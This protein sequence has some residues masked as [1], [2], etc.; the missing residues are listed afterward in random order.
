M[1]R[2]WKHTERVEKILDA[3]GAAGD[4][5]NTLRVQSVL[6]NLWQNGGL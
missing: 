3:A 2:H 4:D 1:R 6:V 5:L